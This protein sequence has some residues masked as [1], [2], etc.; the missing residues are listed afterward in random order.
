MEHFVL[1][2]LFFIV[3]MYGVFL[4]RK[5]GVNSSH[6]RVNEHGLKY[7]FI[8]K[9]GKFYNLRFYDDKNKKWVYVYASSID[10][11]WYGTKFDFRQYK[12]QTFSSDRN[13]LNTINWYR[14]IEQINEE[15]EQIKIRIEQ[16][17]KI[18]EEYVKRDKERRLKEGY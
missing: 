7:Q 1:I 4:C 13:N 11:D 8:N 15:N 17:N 9:L 2:L 18:Q 10:F 12:K 3:I 14:S 5:P 16:N 6:T